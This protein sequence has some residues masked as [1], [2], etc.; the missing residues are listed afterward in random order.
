MLTSELNIPTTLAFDDICTRLQ[1]LPGWT[2]RRGESDM[3]G[4]HITGKNEYNEEVVIHDLRTA[5]E[6]TF[7][8]LHIEF[9]ADSESRVA[10]LTTLCVN[11]LS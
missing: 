8:G 4:S 6:S 11:T 5:Q 2:W 10:E 1:T 7:N 3:L 9:T